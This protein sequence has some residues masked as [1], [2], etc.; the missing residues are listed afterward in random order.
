MPT[1]KRFLVD[2]GCNFPD[3]KC[4][5]PDFAFSENNRKNYCRAYVKFLIKKKLMIKEVSQ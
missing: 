5:V 3:C 4:S 1:E 2:L